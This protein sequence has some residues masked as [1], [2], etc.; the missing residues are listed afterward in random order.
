[1]AEVITPVE[2]TEPDE[3][4]EG[5]QRETQLLLDFFSPFFLPFM[6]RAIL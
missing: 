5:L 6:I 3:P 4:D 1:M 2:P